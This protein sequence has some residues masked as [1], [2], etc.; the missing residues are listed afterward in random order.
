MEEKPVPTG[1][2][3][4]FEI[5]ARGDLVGHQ[6]SRSG[7]EIRS[8]VIF[9]ERGSQTPKEGEYWL[10]QLVKDT[11]PDNPRK[12]AF[13]V[14]L[15][16]RPE[17]K[18]IW[19]GAPLPNGARVLARIE[20]DF[21][22]SFDR[23]DR[24]RKEALERVREG[25]ALLRLSIQKEVES[26]LSECNQGDFLI[27]NYLCSLEGSKGAAGVFGDTVYVTVRGYNSPALEYDGQMIP[28]SVVWAKTKGPSTQVKLH[29]GKS[30]KAG[31][32]FTWGCIS[33]FEEMDTLRFSI[34]D[35]A[36]EFFVGD[37][38]VGTKL[39]MEYYSMGFHTQ[40][41]PEST[42]RVDKD[43]YHRSCE[44]DAWTNA[45]IPSEEHIIEAL[46][47][48]DYV[49]TL[50]QLTVET[51]TRELAHTE[52]VLASIEDVLG[53][54]ALETTTREVAF[55]HPDE[56]DDWEGRHLGRRGTYSTYYKVEVT[57]NGMPAVTE[58]TEN[59]QYGQAWL[60]TLL[61]KVWSTKPPRQ[62]GT[63]PEDPVQQE[64]YGRIRK[65]QEREKLLRE[66]SPEV[67]ERVRRYLEDAVAAEAAKKA[68]EDAARKAAE[69]AD[70]AIKASKMRAEEDARFEAQM[71]EKRVR[72]RE[73]LE[74][75]FSGRHLPNIV[76]ESGRVWSVRYLST[77]GKLFEGA[78]EWEA[79]KQFLHARASGVLSEE[80]FETRT[81]LLIDGLKR[82]LASVIH[83]LDKFQQDD[84]RT[85]IVAA[86][87]GGFSTRGPTILGVLREYAKEERGEDSV[88]PTIRKM[89]ALYRV[90][91]Q[92]I[93]KN[94]GKQRDVEYALGK[95]W[96]GTGYFTQLD[97]STRNTWENAIEIYELALRENGGTALS[98]PAEEKQVEQEAP[99]PAPP[100]GPPVSRATLAG[101]LTQFGSK[102]GKKR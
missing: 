36:I 40:K 13:I 82:E 39:F 68:A 70:Q 54:E 73:K 42:L 19:E 23:A 15:I 32:L 17:A 74:P 41:N 38:A 28:S 83:L 31:F 24:M 93:R 58:A 98:E 44:G 8:K 96:P 84:I 87:G 67:A 63:L 94:G 61:G 26:R 97:G 55:T 30:G 88:L 57:V 86:Y 79:L 72:E 29:V 46:K 71:E 10:C 102:K 48:F 66:R 35:S 95:N 90:A 34:R 2:L 18:E 77:K 37:T 53:K 45:G 20:N 14:R 25:V 100:P 12:G 60:A 76:H 22:L 33:I 5:S 52:E 7:R 6:C 101:F 3:V 99:A 27:G 21:L 51:W 11:Q 65:A 75:L 43:S 92:T 69:A 80:E 9:P 85:V 59:A 49:P 47:R 81:T 89:V 64:L 91:E 4:R 56:D 78:S 1:L 62:E 50:P 16:A